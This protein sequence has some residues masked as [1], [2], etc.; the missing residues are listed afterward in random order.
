[1]QVLALFLPRVSFKLFS[2]LA[3][4]PIALAVQPFALSVRNSGDESAKK[5]EKHR[6]LKKTGMGLLKKAGF[7]GGH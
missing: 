4:T 3:P 7:S 1:V 2:A 6:L 5:S